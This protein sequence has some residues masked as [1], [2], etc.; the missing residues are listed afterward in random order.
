VLLHFRRANLSLCLLMGDGDGRY[1]LRALCTLTYHNCG[2]AQAP[3]AGLPPRAPSPAPRRP[4]PVPVPQPPPPPA[5]PERAL[6][7]RRARTAPVG[8]KRRGARHQ[9]AAWRDVNLD[10]QFWRRHRAAVQEYRWG[11]CRKGSFFVLDKRTGFFVLTQATATG[12]YVCVPRP[13]GTQRRGP[14]CRSSL[15]LTLHGVRLVGVGTPGLEPLWAFRAC[16]WGG[17]EGHGRWL[18]ILPAA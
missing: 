5:Y 11:A 6:R 10:G 9:L 12:V 3:P 14:L 4:A 8:P 16:R 18:E 1:A 7:R 15:L 17:V 13:H 2:P